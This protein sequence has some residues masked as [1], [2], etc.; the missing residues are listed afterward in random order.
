MVLTLKSVGLSPEIEDTITARVTMS[1]GLDLSSTN[2]K[3]TADPG[4]SPEFS[5]TAKNGDP[6]N[7]H[8]IVFEVLDAGDLTV[9]IMG[10]LRQRF[11]A[12]EIKTIQIQVRVPDKM[13]AGD[14]AFSVKASF[15]DNLAVYDKL[16]FTVTVNKKPKLDMTVSPKTLKMKVAETAKFTITFTNGGNVIEDRVLDVGTG[17]SVRASSVTVK[18]DGKVVDSLDISIKPGESLTVALELEVSKD[19]NNGD[20][21][22]LTIGVKERSGYA[23]VEA[24]TVTID[25]EKEVSVL[26]LLTDWSVLAILALFLVIVVL[27]VRL[28]K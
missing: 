9:N 8:E 27:Y 10:G 28:R 21:A 13:T 20:Q 5:M 24:Q 25:I 14:H 22:V 2:L 18:L 1:T 6:M 7:S 15:A 16:T 11:S 17:G 26:D 23:S 12:R 3:K 4:A 19:A